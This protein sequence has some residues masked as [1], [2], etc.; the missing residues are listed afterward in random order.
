MRHLAPLQFFQL[1]QQSRLL[2]RIEPFFDSSHPEIRREALFAHAYDNYIRKE[3]R[4]RAIQASSVRY[5]GAQY[6]TIIHG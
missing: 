3:Q 1:E 2:V 4:S 6:S 5:P